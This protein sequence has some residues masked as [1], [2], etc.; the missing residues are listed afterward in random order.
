MISFGFEVSFSLPCRLAGEESF[1][2]FFLL[3][4]T[5][6]N[7]V[8]CNMRV[9]PHALHVNTES[10]QHTVFTCFR[11]RIHIHLRKHLFHLLYF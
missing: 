10:Y 11:K 7:L 8:T 6:K 4:C 9:F 3:I 2:A 1:L 5:Y